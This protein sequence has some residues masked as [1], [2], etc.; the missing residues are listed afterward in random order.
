MPK[1]PRASK[2]TAAFLNFAV[3]Q[4]S[5][6]A[7]LVQRDWL[8]GDPD[9]DLHGSLQQAMVVLGATAC[10]VSL[11]S[12][13]QQFPIIS[14]LEPKYKL[15]TDLQLIQQDVLSKCATKSVIRTILADGFVATT[16]VLK[17]VGNAMHPDFCSIITDPSRTRIGIGSIIEAGR[18]AEFIATA[19]L[20]YQTLRRRAILFDRV[21]AVVSESYW[22]AAAAPAETNQRTPPWANGGRTERTVTLAI[23]IRK[24]TFCMGQAAVDADYADWL[25]QFVRVTS[26]VC[27]VHGGVFDQFTGDGAL[28]HFLNDET[29]LACDRSPMAAAL[30]C[31]VDL[32]RAMDLHLAVL[33][34]LVRHPSDVVGGAV[35]LDVATASWSMAR[36]GMP[37]VVGRGVVDACRL[38]S[39]AGP[40]T[41]NMTNIFKVNLLAAV[42]CPRALDASHEPGA[43]RRALLTT[44]ELP[45]DLACYMYQLAELPDSIGMGSSRVEQLYRRVVGDWRPRAHQMF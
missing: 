4:E 20:V 15:E 29:R 2:R 45:A 7:E 32:L 38:S 36:A 1:K 31:A 25:D 14:W 19:S 18:Q 16:W 24:S 6:F 12:R 34:S 44:K 11:G 39:A 35:G 33:R 40:R 23:D 28:I 5:L 41:I 10:V 30:A 37:I 9:R 26:E 17:P 13:G 8:A 42:D 3:R 43:L 21:P 27:A 22:L